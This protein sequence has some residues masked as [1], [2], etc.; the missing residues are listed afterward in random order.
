V[1][2]KLEG[3]QAGQLLGVSLESFDVDFL[4]AIGAE[5]RAEEE[6]DDFED[7]EEEAAKVSAAEQET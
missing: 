5:D 3:G 2:G 1:G 6:D 7:E 4:K